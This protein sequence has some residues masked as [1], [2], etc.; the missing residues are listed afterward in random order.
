M[1]I[2]SSRFRISV[3]I[4]TLGCCRC[5][6]AIIPADTTVALSHTAALKRGAVL[7][8]ASILDHRYPGYRP[9]LTLYRTFLLFSSAFSALEPSSLVPAR[10]SLLVSLGS[11]GGSF[12]GFARRSAFWL[13]HSRILWLKTAFTAC[14]RENQE[15]YPDSA[16]PMRTNI[17]SRTDDPEQKWN[18]QSVKTKNEEPTGNDDEE[19]DRRLKLKTEDGAEGR[20]TVHR[21]TTAPQGFLCMW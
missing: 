4:D 20:R 12:F 8:P 18:P 6:S 17:N 19:I 3:T 15:N 14:E 7:L 11:R 10:C 21:P 9:L 2:P 1:C 13:T 16:F 5:C